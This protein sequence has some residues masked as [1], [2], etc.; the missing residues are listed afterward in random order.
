[1]L[2]ELKNKLAN[3]AITMAQNLFDEKG[4]PIRRDLYMTEMKR[5][6]LTTVSV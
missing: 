1:L 3:A 2:L 5:R 4:V 6:S